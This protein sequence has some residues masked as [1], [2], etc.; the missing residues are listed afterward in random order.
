MRKQKDVSIKYGNT[1][2]IQI[3]AHTLKIGL[4]DRYRIPAYPQN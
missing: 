4:N 1:G 2:D 3:R